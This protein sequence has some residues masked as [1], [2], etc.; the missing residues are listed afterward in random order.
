[1]PESRSNG[2]TPWGALERSIAPDVN[3]THAGAAKC[4]RNQPL[5][6][7]TRGI[8]FGAEER[9]PVALRQA[10]EPLDARREVGRLGAPLDIDAPIGM[11]KL[12]ALGASAEL[13][14]EED[15]FDLARRQDLHQC[16]L[17]KPPAARW[18][19]GVESGAAEIGIVA[20]VRRRKGRR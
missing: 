16:R 14:A 5:A 6:V 7:T 15:V 11:I 3:D 8:L 2:A 17:A 18:R 19:R 20:H 1:M 12:G 13:A 4:G 9:G 10:H